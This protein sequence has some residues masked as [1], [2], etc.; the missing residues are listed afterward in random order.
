MS[1]IRSVFCS[2]LL[3]FGC[4]LG[5]L[6][7]CGDPLANV[8]ITL[9]G[10]NVVEQDGMY[11]V[12]LVQDESLNV[13]TTPE[14]GGAGTE[15][16]EVVDTNVATITA[17]VEGVSGDIQDSVVWNY[18]SKFLAITYLNDKH[19]EATISGLN[20]TTVGTVVTISS[21]ESQDIYATLI[22]NITVK[23]QGATLAS[24]MTDFGIPVGQAY[25]L[26]PKRLFEF[27]PGN[28]TVPE[29]TFEIGDDTVYSNQ[30][31]T[32]LNRPTSGLVDI[33]A[34]P[35]N[36]EDFTDEQF[37]A[38]TVRIPN[39]RIYTA[40]TAEN[41]YLSVYG[42]STET[43]QLELIENTNANNVTLYLNTPDAENVEISIRDPNGILDNN[44]WVNV[45]SSAKTVSFTGL[46]PLD[47]W[48]EIYFDIK[49][50]GV[51]DARTVT[52]ALPVRVVDVPENIIINNNNLSTPYI[53]NVFDR[54][55]DEGVNSGTQLN[56]TLSPQS[57]I[58]N[59]VRLQVDLSQTQDPT[60]VQNL[61][62]NGQQFTDNYMTISG[63]TL[64]LRST[65]G[66]GTIVLNVIASDTETLGGDIVSRDLVI[67]MQQ[68]VTDISVNSRYFDS[69]TNNI[70]LQKDSYLAQ[71][72]FQEKDIPFEILPATASYETVS[73]SNSN[74]S[75]VTVTRDET[76]LGMLHIVAVSAGTATIMLTADSGVRYSF[77]V[78]VVMRFNDMTINL[79]SSIGGVL[80]GPYETSDVTIGDINT[81]TL[82]YAFL[83]SASTVHLDN[84]LYPQNVGD[85]IQSISITS[86]NEN[87]AYA[88]PIGYND[89]L[90]ETHRSGTAD[91]TLSVEYYRLATVGQG[92]GINL[93]L[94]TMTLEFTINVFVPISGINLVASNDLNLLADWAN[95]QSYY[96]SQRST[97][98]LTVEVLPQNSDIKASSAVWTVR[99]ESG[100]TTNNLTLSNERGATTTITAQPLTS[101]QSRITV[102]VTVTITDINGI[103]FS[104][105]ESVTITK[106]ALVTELLLNGYGDQNSEGLY[107]EL[108]QT[109]ARFDLDLTVMPSNAT[110]TNVE[111]II[112]DANKLDSPREGSNIVRLDS[113]LR[114]SNGQIIY[115]YYEVLTRTSAYN[116]TQYE[117]YTASVRYDS[118]SGNYYVEPKNAGYAFLFIVPQDILEQS[119]DSIQTL[120]P[121]LQNPSN[122]PVI[123]RIPITVADGIDVRYRL[124][125]A[126]D[127][128]EI[129]KS[130]RGLSSNYYLMN[131]IDM[132]NYL[133]R[134]PDWT[135]IGDATTPFSGSIISMGCENGNGTIQSIVGWNIRKELNEADPQYS[136]THSMYYGIFGVVTGEI[137][138]VNF[139][140]NSYT[141]LQTTSRR[142]YSGV[143]SRNNYDYGLLVGR[144]SSQGDQ[145][146]TLDHV[147][148]N[149]A[150]V[151]YANN[152]SQTGVV[153][154]WF[155]LGA[156]GQVGAECV[157]DNFSSNITA[158][159]STDALKVSFGAIAGRNS[160]SIGT[161]LTTDYTNFAVSNVTISNYVEGEPATLYAGSILGSAVGRNYSASALYG[162]SVD[163]SIDTGQ[164]EGIILGG[165]VGENA[166][167]IQYSMSSTKLSGNGVLGGIAGINSSII[168]DVAY[169]IYSTAQSN[170]GIDGYGIIGG[171][172]GRMTAGEISYAIV[173]GYNITAD[174]PNILG[175]DA[176]LGGL[177]GEV[178]LN[179]N[180]VVQ[181]SFVNAGIVNSNGT[182]GG[183]VGRATGNMSINNV[184]VRGVLAGESNVIG[185][186]A[187]EVTDN[188]LL[189]SAVYAEF[190]SDTDLSAT[191]SGNLNTASAPASTV[192]LVN[193]PGSFANSGNL[194]YFDKNDSN[195]TNLNY[196]TS[197]FGFDSD[198]WRCSAEINGGYPYLVRADGTDFVR[199]VPNDFF[200][201]A[202]AFD[203]YTDSRLNNILNV[204]SESGT[205]DTKKLII[206]Y[207]ADNPTYNLSD[208]FTFS[209]DPILNVNNVRM[210]IA[211]SSTNVVQLFTGATFNDARIRI[212]GTGTAVLS[213][214]SLQNNNAR[215]YVQIAVIN[216]Y[217]YFNL[218][219]G[220]DSSG[221]L[222][223]NSTP[224]H[225]FRIKYGENERAFVE[226]INNGEAQDNVDG[227]L[228]FTVAD[229]TVVSFGLDEW[230]EDGDN[231]S[232]YL[233]GENDI[234]I[235]SLRYSSEPLLVRVTPFLVATFFN[236]D[237][238]GM[239]TS[240]Y[241]AYIDIDEDEMA[242]N[243]DTLVYRGANGIAMGIADDTQVYAEDALVASVTLFTDNYVEGDM[244]LEHVGYV[245]TIYGTQDEVINTEIGLESPDMVVSFGTLEYD[246]LNHSLVIP[247]TIRLTSSAR[248]N[249]ESILRYTITFW[250]NDTDGNPITTMTASLS[251]GFYPQK[252]DYIG[253]AH[254]SDAVNNGSRLQQAG[255]EA[256]NTLIAGQYGLLV[257]Q[258]SP[259]FAY[260]DRIEILSD[261]VNGARIM[262][263]QRV[264]SYDEKNIATYWSW[265]QG[266]EIVSNGIAPDRV[267]NIDGTFDGS[268]YIRTIIS[269][270]VPVG[271]TFTVT[272]NIY[273]DD[274]VIGTMSLPLTV[275][276]Q[277][278][279]LLSYSNYNSNVNYAYV[280]EG[281]GLVA[282]MDTLIQNQNELIV[283][284]G[285]SFESFTLEVDAVSS[286]YGAQIVFS[287]GRYYLYTGTV[288]AGEMITVTLT[289]RQNMSGLINEISR[290]LR[291]LVVN[292]YISS[293][294]DG[295]V[296][297][298]SQ[299]TSLRYAYVNGRTYDLRIFEGATLEN[300]D[301][302]TAIT[303]N[304][305]SDT[306][307]QQIMDVI[308][309][310]NGIGTRPYAGWYAYVPQSDGTYVWSLID[311]DISYTEDNWLDGNYRIF[312]ETLNGS[313]TGYTLSANGVSNTSR[314]RYEMYFDYEDG[315]F[316]LLNRSQIANSTR[317]FS[318]N[319]ITLNFFQITSQE[320]AQPIYTERDLINMESGLDY[321]LMNDI[322]ITSNWTPIS[323]EISS[324]NG[325]G[326]TIRFTPASISANGQNFGLFGIVAENT[327][328][329]NVNLQLGTQ[330]L[331]LPSSVSSMSSI[332]FGFIAGTNNGTI[333]NCSVNGWYEAG[334]T[335]IGV[336]VPTPTD[337]QALFNIAGLVGTNSA[338][339]A[340]SNSRVIYTD[341]TGYGRVAGLVSINEGAIASSYYTGGVLTNVASTTGTNVA[342]AGLVVENGQNATI[343][344]SFTGGAY[345]SYDAETGQNTLV[346][347]R[348]TERDA[349]IQSG[350]RSA[351]FVYSNNGSITDSYSS[352]RILSIEA[353]GFVYENGGAGTIYRCYTTSILSDSSN[354]GV[355]SVSMPFIGIS[356]TQATTNNNLNPDG[357]IDCY[358]YDTGFSANALRLEEAK[359]LTLNQMLGNSG[360]NVFNNFI[361]SRDGESGSE[362][363]GNWIFVSPDN[364]YFTPTRFVTQNGLQSE[365]NFGPKLVSASLIATPRLVLDEE[366]TAENPDT[367]AIEYYYN[368]VSSPYFISG[369][370]ADFN[371]DY[372][373]DP[374]TITTALQFSQAFDITLDS[375]VT[376]DYTEHE[377]T[378]TKI[379]GDVRLARNIDQSDISVNTALTSPNVNYAGI[380]EGNGFTFEN[381]N[382]AVNDES[383]DRYGLF[384]TISYGDRLRS[385]EIA[386]IG[387]VKNLNI[388]VSMV[389]CSLVDYVGALAGVVENANIYNIAVTGQSSRVVGNNAVGGVAGLLTG[390][391]KANIISANVGVTANY[392]ADT[393]LV[394]N[395]DIARILGGTANSITRMGFA[396]GVFGI[397]DLTQFGDVKT[398]T[399]PEEAVLNNITAYGQHSV[400]GKIAGG[401]VGA[402]GMH[403]VLNNATTEIDTSTRI[404]GLTY[405]GG[406]VGQNNGVIRYG[407]VNYTADVQEAVDVAN[408]GEDTTVNL[409]GNNITVNNMI[410]ETEQNNLGTGGIVGLNIGY[411]DSGWPSGMIYYT[412]SKVRVRNTHSANV[413]GI[414]GIAMGGDIRAV[415]ATGGVYGS[416]TAYLGGIVGQVS[417]FSEMASIPEGLNN[418]FAD[419]NNMLTTLDYCVALN[420]YLASDYNYY[421]ELDYQGTGAQGGLVGYC[422]NAGMIYTTHTNDTG[423]PSTP[424]YEL[425][426]SI[427]FYVNQIYDRVVLNTVTEE[428]D[429]GNFINLDAVGRFEPGTS[430]NPATGHTRGYM[431]NN[432]DEI[433][434]GWDTY[435]ISN[436]NGIPSIDIQ[437]V[438]E[439]MYIYTASDYRKMYWHPDIDYVL[440]AD[441]DF[442][443]EGV[444]AVPIG[445]ESAPFTGSFNGN[446]HTLYNIPLVMTGAMNAGMFGA[447]DGATIQNVNIVNIYIS[448]DLSE[449]ITGYVGGLAGVVRDSTITNVNIRM[450]STLEGSYHGID[451]TA[452][453]TGGMFGRVYATTDGATTITNCYVYAD[454]TTA[455]NTYT[456]ATDTFIGGFAG[457]IYGN[458]T[459]ENAYAEGTLTQ[460]NTSM[461]NVVI[462]HYIGGFAG[463]AVASN[464]S[465]A[466]SALDVTIDNVY[467][468]VYAGGF[469]GRSQNNT[470]A[471]IDSATNVTVNL[472]NLT[473]SYALNLGGLFGRSEGDSVYYFANSGDLEINGNYN[474]NVDTT[475]VS[476][477][478]AVAGVVGV[479]MGS[480]IQSGY[481]IA[482]IFNNTRLNNVDLAVFDGNLESSVYCDA[483][484]GLTARDRLSL[485]RNS[486]VVLGF[487]ITDYLE[488]PVGNSYAR[489]VV[490]NWST[491]NPSI[492]RYEALYSNTVS[493]GDSKRAPI[494][495]SNSSDFNAIAE[496]SGDLYKYYLQ[497][498]TV[499]SGIN[500][501]TARTLY[502]WYNAG[503]NYVVANEIDTLDYTVFT[504][505]SNPYYGIFSELA[506]VNGKGSIFSGARI[507]V[508]VSTK[509]PANAVFGGA[510][511]V[512][513]EQAKIFSTY[514][515]ADLD[516]GV[517]SGSA[518]IGALAGINRGQI[519]GSGA[520][521][522]INLYG[523]VSNT[524]ENLNTGGSVN[525]G[526]LVGWSTN[527]D[528]RLTF[529]DSYAIG[530]ITN[531][532]PNT[533]SYIAGLVGRVSNES[534]GTLNFYNENTYT[535]VTLTDTT[536]QVNTYSV[537][538]NY[539]GATNSQG[540][541]YERS[542]T[543]NPLIN[544]TSFTISNQRGD[545][546]LN[547]G[548]AFTTESTLNY[549]LPYFKWLS[550]DDLRSTG[551]GT[552]NNPYLINSAGLLAWALNN[553]N[554]VYY[555]LEN[556]IDYTYMANIYS[557]ATAFIGT[558][559]GQ[560]NAITGVTSTL[561]GTLSGEVSNLAIL[562]ST[563]GTTLANT[564][565]G[566]A[567]SIY[568]DSTTGAVVGSGNITNS[569]SAGATFG[570]NAVACFTSN[571]TDIASLDGNVWV[572]TGRTADGSKVYDLRAFVPTIGE[573]ASFGTSVS[574]NASEYVISNIDEFERIVEYINDHGG[575]DYYI[576]FT[577]TIFSLN[578]R[579]LPT[580]G[581]T[582]TNTD[583]FLTVGGFRDGL[584]ERNGTN[585]FTNGLSNSQVTNLENMGV[586][587]HGG[588]IFG[589]TNTKYTSATTGLDLVLTDIEVYA[590][591]DA[592]LVINTFDR[593][594]TTN[595]ALTNVN[596]Y[597]YGDIALYG[598]GNTIMSNATV[599]VN[600]VNLV[601][602]NMTAFVATN[603]GTLNL[604][605][606]ANTTINSAGLNSV[607]LGA[608]TNAGTI[609]LG[610]V[611][612][613]ISANSIGG[614]AITNTGTISG[615]SLSLALTGA[616][617]Y[618]IASD[619]QG[620]ITN[621]TIQTST[622]NGNGSATLVGTN[623]GSV[624]ATIGGAVTI[625][626][627]NTAGLFGTY[628]A[629]DVAI[630]L[631][632]NIDL[633]GSTVSAFATT[634]AELLTPDTQIT[635]SGSI[636]Q[637]TTTVLYP[638]AIQY[639]IT[640]GEGGTVQITNE[641]GATVTAVASANAG[642]EFVGWQNSAG[643]IVGSDTTL[644]IEKTA[645]AGDTITAIFQAVTEPD[646]EQPTT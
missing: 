109:N 163:G 553:S 151:V 14:E 439:I 213:F 422:F 320:H 473:S 82:N 513:G 120:T 496:D 506:D 43:T 449:G 13:P 134:N 1:K 215:D 162:V 200:I 172:V 165:V 279:L 581:N 40:L 459:I 273:A 186:I 98:D 180:A 322:T 239:V 354:E 341:I 350:A 73:F 79:N 429:T 551:N 138:Y 593:N 617:S 318:T 530:S 245:V 440:M 45:N 251:W 402:L 115:D 409:E 398:T 416:R 463:Q 311:P 67:R 225:E 426:N 542:T 462:T 605:S 129:G 621:V 614:I 294:Q 427:N 348:R 169:E 224:A 128:A 343:F 117:S 444:P 406:L 565:S 173:Q 42:S 389:S 125:S 539:S 538:A 231:Y 196:Y 344:G 132:S 571:P 587:L 53:L 629:G 509:L 275:E 305:S 301:T 632:A 380:F 16:P 230:V 610:T 603:N 150:N 61:L 613:S 451:S 297:G 567:T 411:T 555:A 95:I 235:V 645:I 185:A 133:A 585:D 355:T 316:T 188:L 246:E 276:Q 370:N 418:P 378:V 376:Y 7:G 46:S 315:I 484:L 498:S 148:V 38:L 28:A 331:A 460:T 140:L 309:R 589:S 557:R 208:L 507:Q 247:Y 84:T 337:T 417:N 97:A 312:T 435:S 494:L 329:K 161:N 131:T 607:T 404:T 259:Y 358:F 181:N 66:Y 289:G 552:E 583:V 238:D 392:K 408:T 203:T 385:S 62:V 250:A 268:Y 477:I 264:L 167:T 286:S 373:Y 489:L 324:L 58:Y 461:S 65:G 141:I 278:T 441:I 390:T 299:S 576:R 126:E 75:V 243:Y 178:A 51:A 372:S 86:S 144:L 102:Q 319:D 379:I 332:N 17:I 122:S 564:V 364:E 347:S 153:D 467:R 204:P 236:L 561:I 221:T 137:R 403:S 594:T 76:E 49:V 258:V 37:E 388:E 588:S 437:D 511:S 420:N 255:Q 89:I 478:H 270:L 193:N 615:G 397:V 597:T 69:V 154:L 182:L 363:T 8:R 633:I 187:G 490:D 197:Q 307:R 93:E 30:E 359:S 466:V 482:S 293:I 207:D 34:Y 349:S 106:V 556:D 190:T 77:N 624:S 479:N 381:L 39:V 325:N 442:L 474:V 127:V 179:S 152:N 283:E 356:G 36:R 423:D 209:S 383:V 110:N 308:N 558:L 56:I 26:D 205:T 12:N 2:L 139:Y 6:A 366:R 222:I 547:L 644:T 396:G 374:V 608:T 425:I 365:M 216:G 559:D 78:Q 525:L 407:E 166:G 360:K 212:V 244:V 291:F 419:Y 483:Y 456:Q 295:L 135:P 413:G 476:S 113:G 70:V 184:Y 387:T 500:L 4:T 237:E 277:D 158:R 265:Q 433:F 123:R 25:T 572:Y 458:V 595:I 281:T 637:N 544:F 92:Y 590:D 502:G 536:G 628:T 326:Y 23:P 271:T 228:K 314:I 625:T 241:S 118:S 634:G 405:S 554:A 327:V 428:Q 601:I 641:E 157:V 345:T 443:A 616:N 578:N 415:F 514:V 642:Y 32:I 60:L 183:L 274:E 21:I 627:E 171:L 256:T 155:N 352:M 471:S 599:N 145:V 512:V 361:F 54:Y 522:D 371:T 519:I 643:Q 147:S 382:L 436:E 10:T 386:H 481:S 91:F 323:T 333:H 177:V 176:I 447:T 5:L 586:L 313:Y 81:T 401:V 499:I 261:Y 497:S 470:I 622:I 285:S 516:L 369:T 453:Y 55:A 263:D 3:V 218:Y 194:V 357:I 573:S 487:S 574:L 233:Y 220:S 577:D 548:N 510:V 584:I 282:G 492:Q 195:A 636:T 520:D 524:G 367:G 272:V 541:Y 112:F 430:T 620:S 105:T 528:S 88:T 50:S 292:F 626:G 321:I 521:V 535:A 468:S 164:N 223:Q 29:Y 242:L 64:Y 570:A 596:V 101:M 469:V 545:S 384:G 63:T 48:T 72:S 287:G 302:I 432:F 457:E 550:T 87:V 503:G 41:T 488:S 160:G 80:L 121:Q 257:V 531:H 618:L 33:V 202:R 24:N 368:Q 11:Y 35:T 146:G 266:V 434:G 198:R 143:A 254:F 114:D 249:L 149:C 414:V 493:A 288:P 170:C 450:D 226:Y 15:T 394:Y 159:I 328:I 119:A 560:G 518:N 448:T 199:V 480:N 201:N 606:I 104:E 540:V 486:R 214:V 452:T 57:N 532:N 579:F 303:F 340:I 191:G 464:I 296:N 592:S 504:E 262:F 103:V 338:T 339:G 217:E 108:Y 575:T 630:T 523:S 639:T 638:I 609:T 310:L 342:T 623:S 438:P 619:N 253:I 52:K 31:F 563:A 602:N 508:S 412:S 290:E 99:S 346:E 351:G 569:L 107:F 206:F 424:Y 300:L 562:N 68:G 304:P 252:I 375:V 71:S 18:D 495:V 47:E 267:S 465:N 335:S 192:I 269:Q 234:T 362:F 83:A 421:N 211:C 260:Y 85:M 505:S 94:A 306:T 174:S 533:A 22:V 529:I 19:T 136:S 391:T 566:L 543:I 491:F 475:T 446:N 517:A 59:N 96:D 646:P 330:N 612:A 232:Y 399:N 393:E 334:R 455:D 124:Y 20:P 175:H 168:N 549:G 604:N 640:A 9:E 130:A 90:L 336:T 189:T 431:L 377:Q 515:T 454:M 100:G 600:A 537:V 210:Q 534:G 142:D 229:N 472:N 240:S 27:T 598:I 400:V 219:E 445:S 635:G 611:T 501:N 111:Y 546:P 580:L 631:S 116:P 44:V 284:V 410:F 353:S 156:I 298:A 227:G 248:D 485:G 582:T 395:A 317:G 74:P 527:I 526:G 568:T 280:A 591:N